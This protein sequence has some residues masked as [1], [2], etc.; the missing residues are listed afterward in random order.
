[1]ERLQGKIWRRVVDRDVLSRVQQH[2]ALLSTKLFAGQTVVRIYSETAP[3]DGFQ[4]A[5]PGLEDVYFAAMHGG[6]GA[7][8]SS[9]NGDVGVA[10]Q[11]PTAGAA[12]GTR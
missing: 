4:P 1:V 11:A 7:S 3:G 12:P 6:R 10:A 8:V 2:G 5:D 9:P